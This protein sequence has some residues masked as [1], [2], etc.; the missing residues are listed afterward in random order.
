M[1]RALAGACFVLAVA[2]AAVLFLSLRVPLGTK[3]ETTVRAET[4][5][6]DAARGVAGSLPANHGLPAH[7]IV[8]ILPAVPYGDFYLDRVRERLGLPTHAQAALSPEQIRQFA[9]VLRYAS[10]DQHGRFV[11]GRLE[12]G[13]YIAVATATL[14][15]GISVDVAR[16]AVPAGRSVT[17]AHDRFRPLQEV[18]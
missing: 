12:P 8:Q 7:Y 1:L 18:Q 15:N 5:A 10:I 6:P 9:A 3:L 16:F 2:G 4:C 11:C 14:A 13:S 17:L